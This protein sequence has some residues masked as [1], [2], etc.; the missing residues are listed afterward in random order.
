MYYSVLHKL[1]FKKTNVNIQCDVIQ[2]CYFIIDRRR[3][4]TKIWSKFDFFLIQNI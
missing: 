4:S 3:L 2:E 1:L